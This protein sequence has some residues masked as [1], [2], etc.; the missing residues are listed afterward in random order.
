M[1]FDFSVIWIICGRSMANVIAF[2]ITLEIIK[3]LKLMP[4]FDKD[5]PNALGAKSSHNNFLKC[6][7]LHTKDI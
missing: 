2:T 6:H 5:G 3:I 7:I 1:I 4:T